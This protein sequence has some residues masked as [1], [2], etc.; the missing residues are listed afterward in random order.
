MVAANNQLVSQVVLRKAEEHDP[1]RERTIGTIT[2]LDLA[3]PGSANE[4]NYLDLVKG[5]ESMQKLSLNWYVLRN[6]FEDERSSD[7]YTRDANEERFFQT[8]AGSMLILPIA[9]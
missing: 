1:N 7:A 6:R 9:A 2:K 4:R 3:G 8:G 5:R